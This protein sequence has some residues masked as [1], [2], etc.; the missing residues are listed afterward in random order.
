MDTKF[1]LEKDVLF[2]MKLI[3]GEEIVAKLID[4]DDDYYYLNAPF[5]VGATPQGLQ[6]M[7]SLFTSD[8]N[9]DSGMPRFAVT[10]MAPS[11]KDIIVAYEKSVNPSN[12]LTPKKQ[13]ITG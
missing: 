8:K 6:L 9:P 3:S 10:L 2:S 11:R 1:K 7:P 12:I 5:G 4:W 13:I